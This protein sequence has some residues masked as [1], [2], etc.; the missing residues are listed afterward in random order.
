M[1]ILGTSL[2][3]LLI[4]LDIKPLLSL[5]HNIKI[6]YGANF[7]AIWAKLVIY[8]KPFFNW[9]FL[10]S[11]SIPFMLVNGWA[12]V[13]VFLFPYIKNW[14]TITSVSW[15]TFLWMPFTPEKLFTI[16]FAIWIH[17]QLF[18]NDP[19]TKQ[20]LERMYTEAKSDWQKIKERVRK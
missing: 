19:H 20:Q 11:Y 6:D 18:K 12:W 8:I 5:I 13:G 14:F 10:I 2:I 17:T 16:P 4:V 7:K 1:L 15:M 3:S 9:R